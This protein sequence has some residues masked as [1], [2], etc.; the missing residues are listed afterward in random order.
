MNLVE[1]PRTRIEKI[2]KMYERGMFLRQ[3]ADEF[4]ITRQRVQQLMVR[5]PETR[6]K[7]LFIKYG[8]QVVNVEKR[9][10]R[11]DRP[12]TCFACGKTFYP[13]D[14]CHSETDI[15]RLSGTSRGSITI[16]GKI[17]CPDCFVPARLAYNA[18]RMNR[19]YHENK[20]SK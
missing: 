14:V 15:R 5:T 2:L 20:A 8:R 9:T 18:R 12:M 3:I 4:G 17:Y 13:R 6:A 7:Y 1:D 16:E 11:K 10:P 19:W